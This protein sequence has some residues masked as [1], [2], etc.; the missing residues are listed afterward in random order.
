MINNC[1]KLKIVDNSGVKQIKIIK[2]YKKTPYSSIKVGNFFIGSIKKIKTKRKSRIKKLTDGELKKSILLRSKTRIFRR[3][4]STL[5]FF[6][7]AAVLIDN[8]QKPIATR[9][10]GFV[11][12]EL[13]K[14]KNLKL[15]F[16]SAGAFL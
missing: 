4:G 7:N 10:K 1:S 2:F 6:E 3:D 14:K 5:R 15:V 12:L 8:K 11:P 9:I 13:K 16:L